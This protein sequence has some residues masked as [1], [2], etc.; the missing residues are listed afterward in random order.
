MTDNNNPQGTDLSDAANAINAMLAPEGDNVTDVDAPDIEEEDVDLDETDEDE[1][2][3]DESDPDEEDDEGD[4]QDL[5]VDILAAEIEVDGEQIKVEELKNGYLR[6]RDY[7]KKTMELSEARK[8]FDVQVQEVNLERAQYAEI[9]PKLQEKI[10]AFAPQ[11]PD[12]DKLYDADPVG[13]ARMERNWKKQQA[14]RNQILQAAASERDRV[15]AL[16]AAEKQRAFQNYVAKQQETLP[17]VIPEWGDMNVAQR[18]APEVTKFLL[19]EGF[20]EDDVNGV[21]DAKIVKLA[22]MAMLHAKGSKKANEV[23]AKP[24]MQK[25]KTM[26]GGS[27][28]TAPRPKSEVREAQ[29]RLNKSGRISDAAAIIR[30]ML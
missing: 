8:S 17:Q 14:E 19:S 11:E 12:W 20:T 3:S 22:R 30:N 27:T 25:T 4:D 5:S 9:L 13:A 24:Q 15:Q 16:L 10:E 28:N 1:Y 6:Q 29:L 21:F 18:E 7:T 23:K 2:E 26:K